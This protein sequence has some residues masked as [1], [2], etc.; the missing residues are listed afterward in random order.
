M[1]KHEFKL[2]V[3]LLFLLILLNNRANGQ[4]NT[5]GTI[6]KTGDAYNSYTLFSPGGNKVVYLIDNYGRIVHQ[7]E[8][9]YYPGMAVYLMEDGSLFRAGKVPNVKIPGGGAGGNVIKYSWSGDVIWKY[10]ISD[11]FS[12]SHHDFEVLPNGNILM[13]IWERYELEEALAKG[14]NPDKLTGEKLLVEAILEIE[15]LSYSTGNV[16]WEWHAWDHLVQDFDET[17]EETWGVVADNPGRINLNYTNHDRDGYDWQHANSISYNAELDQI[18][19]SVKNFDEIWIIDHST[20]TQEASGEKGDLIFRWGNPITYGAGTVEDQMLF[21]QHDAKWIV[22]GLPDEG[23]ILIFNNGR[24]RPGDDYTSVVKIEPTIGEDGIYERSIENRY[25]PVT[26]DY[27]FKA[28]EPTD[29]FAY[30]ISGAQQLPNGHILICD[31]T[32]GNFFEIDENEE[33]VWRYINPIILGGFVAEQG[34]EPVDSRGGPNNP[35]FR[36]TKYSKDYAAF[37]GRDLTPGAFIELNG[38]LLSSKLSPTSTNVFPNP[39]Q[40]VMNV[41]SDSQINRIQLLNMKGQIVFDKKFHSRTVEILFDR[42]PKGIY[43]MLLNQEPVSKILL[44]R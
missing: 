19:L 42:L 21:A 17:N 7:W 8:T 44:N 32:H 6:I 33:E 22:S 43:Q 15:P 12:R 24:Y 40:G 3:G 16:V 23:K 9:E 2:F 39:T 25:L 14:R 38:I 27:E 41:R 31:G 13:L 11:D 4:D 29:F 10:T 26:Y 30:Y 36:A 20:T 28:E 35:V 37:V 34:Q 1:I 18:M 5:V